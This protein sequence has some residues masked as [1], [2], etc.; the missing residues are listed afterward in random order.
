MAA[1]CLNGYRMQQAGIVA[2][3]SDACNSCKVAT[4]VEGCSG[5]EHSGESSKQR[6]RECRELGEISM[7]GAE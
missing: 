4:Q 6:E 2:G 7:Q 5:D 3:Y 1:D